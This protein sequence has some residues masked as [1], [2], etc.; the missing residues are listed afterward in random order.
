MTKLD[1]ASGSR[2]AKKSRT[3]GSYAADVA[4]RDEVARKVC[5][6]R[7]RVDRGELRPQEFAHEYRGTLRVAALVLDFGDVNGGPDRAI[8][9]AERLGG[10]AGLL[11]GR[12]RIGVVA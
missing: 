5:E 2:R 6:H 1:R 8:I 12:D 7:L 9:V 11:E 10:S 4:E 3:T